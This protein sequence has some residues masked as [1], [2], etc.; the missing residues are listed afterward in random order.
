M[1][2]DMINMEIVTIIITIIMI[3]II[4]RISRRKPTNWDALQRTHCQQTVHPRVTSSSTPTHPCAQPGDTDSTAVSEAGKERERERRGREGG[5][6][7]EGEGRERGGR[8]G[9]TEREG[10]GRERGGRDE[11][12]ER[13][14][15][16]ERERERKGWRERG[17]ERERERVEREKERERERGGGVVG[18]EFH[19]AKFH[20]EMPA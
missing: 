6:E 4:C 9:G 2:V 15:K 17:K 20:R 5:T 12:R 8:E 13:E 7:R 1:Y 18:T 10:E 11:E 16:R 14:R 3:V 19:A